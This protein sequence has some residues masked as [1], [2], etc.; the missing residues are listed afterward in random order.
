MKAP[1]GPWTTGIDAEPPCQLSHFWK[2]RMTMLPLISR[3]GPQPSSLG[4]LTLLLAGAVLLA[5]PTLRG[6]TPAT[7]EA[8]GQESRQPPLLLVPASKP[9]STPPPSSAAPVLDPKFTAAAEQALA[10]MSHGF[11]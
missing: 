6:Q 3:S 10:R 4:L 11:S 2:R 7:T 9:Y 5:L 8:N 1:F